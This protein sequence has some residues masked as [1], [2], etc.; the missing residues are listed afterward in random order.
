M[1]LMYTYISLATIIKHIFL[2]PAVSLYIYVPH[3][4]IYFSG[5]NN[6]A[7]ILALAVSIYIYVPH[8]YIYFSGDNNKAHISGGSC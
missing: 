1:F 6:K 4:Y 2:A 8:A 3:V 7:H 5:D